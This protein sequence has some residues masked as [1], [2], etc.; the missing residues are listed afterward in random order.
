ML[1]AVYMGDKPTFDAFWKYAQAHMV[2]GLMSWHLTSTGSVD[3]SDGDGSNSA[4]DADEDM[5]WSLLMA[6]KQWPG[7]TYGTSA[8]S[9]IA[10]IKSGDV[11]GSGQIVDGCCFG[12]S[13]THPDY[14]APNYY[15]AFNFATSVAAEYT[16]LES[17]ASSVGLI[18]DSVG[19]S[20]F[21]YDAC[22]A[23]WRVGLDYCWNGSR[24][25]NQAFLSKM[26]ATLMSTAQ[27]LGGAAKLELPLL[28]SSGQ[29]D[30]ASSPAVT[31]AIIGP[32][33]V[34]AMMSASNQSY[35]DQSATFLATYIGRA[36][37]SGIYGANGDYFGSTVGLIG[38]LAITGNFNDFTNP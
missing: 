36:S 30:T 9:L 3:N 31:G 37:M 32:A 27:T 14:A 23:P 6:D 5:A 8:T 2:N 16:L 22:R 35:I 12:A 11:N 19:G 17:S 7:G 34:G 10:A 26:V 29:P 21:A 13:A 33:A 28:V 25:G 20:D 4:S 15:A 18:P 38:L 1:I 24:N